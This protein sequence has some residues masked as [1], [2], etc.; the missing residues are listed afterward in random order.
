M[1]YNHET[2]QHDIKLHYRYPLVNDGIHYTRDKFSK[3]KWD[4]WGKS[5]RIKKGDQVV[6]LSD[7]K[8]NSNGV[9]NVHST[10]TDFAKF[11]GISTSCPLMTAI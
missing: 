7:L 1:K 9:T 11:R 4:K 2:Q 10:V 6:S 3:I 5:Y 8:N